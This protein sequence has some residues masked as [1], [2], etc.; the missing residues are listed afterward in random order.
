MSNA[1]KIVPRKLYKITGTTEKG[2]GKALLIV[3]RTPIDALHTAEKD[4]YITTVE[5]LSVER[6]LVWTS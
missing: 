6:D 5:T 4:F 2:H 3:S 1:V